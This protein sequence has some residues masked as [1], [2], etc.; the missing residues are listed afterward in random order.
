M[1]AHIKLM[2]EEGNYAEL[3]NQLAE[4]LKSETKDYKSR[5]LL[6]ESLIILG[7]YERADK[8]LNMLFMQTPQYGPTI[9]QY[10]Q[11]IRAATSRR[12]VFEK[13]RAPDLLC[14]AT[15]TLKSHIRL[16]NAITK[17]DASAINDTLP[18]IESQAPKCHFSLNGKTYN[19]IRDADDRT[20]Y[21]VEL[22]GLD[23]SYYLADWQHI[24]T[25][26]FKAAK[27]PHLAQC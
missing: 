13:N 25:M 17:H 4:H 12:E 16:I 24:D 20:A 5:S 10:R 8:Q 26:S 23:G 11:L 15:K 7:D 19:A 22:M 27:R 14:E 3:S 9:N 1:H 18:E 6:A 2:V 21:I